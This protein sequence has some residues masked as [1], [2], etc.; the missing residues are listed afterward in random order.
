[1]IIIPA[2]ETLYFLTE[3]RMKGA[4]YDTYV[5]CRNYGPGVFFMTFR[6]D[7]VEDPSRFKDI[8]LFYPR[9]ADSISHSVCL[10][11][12]KVIFFE[13]FEIAITR[14]FLKLGPPDFAW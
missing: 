9:P 6:S 14:P 12:K 7:F 13:K 3:M 8:I 10:S 5:P 2:S 1:M 11:V 4:Q